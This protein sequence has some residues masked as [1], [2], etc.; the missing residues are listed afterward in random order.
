MW[1]FQ[2]VEVSTKA[3]RIP[4]LPEGGVLSKVACAGGV[5]ATAWPGEAGGAPEGLGVDGVDLHHRAHRH[6]LG[7]LVAQRGQLRAVMPNR[8]GF[9]PVS[10]T[11]PGWFAPSAHASG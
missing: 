1:P 9:V 10:G 2:K 3:M 8:P 11:N 4:G 6:A 7:E 5:S